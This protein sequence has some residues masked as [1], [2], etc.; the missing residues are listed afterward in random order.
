M[1]EYSLADVAGMLYEQ[2]DALKYWIR[3]LGL[4][5]MACLFFAWKHKQAR[6]V[7]IAMLVVAI[8]NIPMAMALGLVKGLS[9]P[10]LVAWVPLT[11]Y[12]AME[13]RNNKVSIGSAFGIWVLVLMVTNTISIVFDIRDSVEY[14]AGDRAIIAMSGISVPYVTIT[15]IV[16]SI[17]GLAYYCRLSVFANKTP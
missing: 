3:W 13:I 16:L 7:A 10:H 4:A 17:I 6:W 15:A 11:V 1:F 12:L 14:I 9:I 8:A 5:N 2:P